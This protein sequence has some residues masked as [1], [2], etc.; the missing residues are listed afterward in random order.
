MEYEAKYYCFFCKKVFLHTSDDRC[1]HAV[2]Y[3]LCEGT[4]CNSCLKDKLENKK[5]V[6]L[7]DPRVASL[8]RKVGPGFPSCPPEVHDEFTKSEED[9]FNKYAPQ[10]NAIAEV[11]QSISEVE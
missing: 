11:L 3:R 4:F 2:R 10:L 7:H 6:I 8:A 5:C 1:S 9:T